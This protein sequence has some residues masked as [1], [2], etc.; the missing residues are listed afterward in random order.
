MWRNVSGAP[1]VHSSRFWY[2]HRITNTGSRMNMGSCL[3]Q[4][5]GGCNVTS[6]PKYIHMER[7]GSAPRHS[8]RIKFFLIMM[9]R[10]RCRDIRHVISNMTS[11]YEFMVSLVARKPI[12]TTCEWGIITRSWNLFMWSIIC[13]NRI[14]LPNLVRWR[15]HLWNLI[16]MISHGVW[17]KVRSSLP[18]LS[19]SLSQRRRRHGSRKYC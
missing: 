17:I 3:H 5:D 1:N 13:A 2:S 14:F 9:C 16:L 4:R 18:G 11:A 12:P 8:A 7:D 10:I 6:G 15:R 19:G